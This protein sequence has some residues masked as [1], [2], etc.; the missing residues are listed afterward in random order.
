MGYILSCVQRETPYEAREFLDL[1]ILTRTVV[2]V[3]RQS[4]TEF[5][6]TTAV[7]GS[8]R[9]RLSNSYAVYHMGGEY[10]HEQ[11]SSYRPEDA[12]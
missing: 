4:Q 2:P 8:F 7:P 12:P 10:M 11:C 9:L 3:V 1:A 6:W 5:G